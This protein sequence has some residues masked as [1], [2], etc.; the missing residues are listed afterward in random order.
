MFSI[1]YNIADAAEWQPLPLNF[2]PSQ[3]VILLQ[4]NNNKL[5]KL[6]WPFME[7]SFLCDQ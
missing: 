1:S 6:A 4:P 5:R 2:R 7:M 3:E